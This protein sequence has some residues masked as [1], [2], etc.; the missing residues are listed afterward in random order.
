MNRAAMLLLKN[1]LIPVERRFF[2]KLKFRT[3]VDQINS[4]GDFRND[5]ISRFFLLNAFG[6]NHQHIR[7]TGFV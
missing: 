4:A 2:A 6:Q 1:N 3:P 5:A 7:L